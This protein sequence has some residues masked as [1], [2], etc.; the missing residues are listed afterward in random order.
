MR[1]EILPVRLIKNFRSRSEVFGVRRSVKYAVKHAI[2]KKTLN[3]EV[4][5][6]A[7]I[8][9]DAGIPV[10]VVAD[11]S[12]AYLEGESALPESR[13]LD[14][15]KQ[16]LGDGESNSDDD[17]FNGNEKHNKR[18]WHAAA[19]GNDKMVLNC[20]RDGKCG[21]NSRDEMAPQHFFSRRT[22][23]T[24]TSCDPSGE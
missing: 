4:E 6:M 5:E 12:V 16:W 13:L 18:L 22:M 10:S 3:D 19:L 8:F 1:A 7:K 24:E 17:E 21:L 9:E 2:G 23:D 20:I 11:G 15:T 14:K